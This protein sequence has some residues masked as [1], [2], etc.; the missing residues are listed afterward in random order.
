MG[1]PLSGPAAV[2]GE[3]RIGF[4]KLTETRVARKYKMSIRR[5]DCQRIER[6]KMLCIETDVIM[7]PVEVRTRD[8]TLQSAAKKGLVLILGSTVLPCS[9]KT[10]VASALYFV[11]DY[12][13]IELLTI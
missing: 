7:S 9:E 8:R 10:S 11:K 4:A 13:M 6:A 3:I 2:C 5:L 12:R 1:A